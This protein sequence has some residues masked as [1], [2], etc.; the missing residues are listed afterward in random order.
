M[1]FQQVLLRRISFLGRYHLWIFH[2][3][4]GHFPLLVAVGL[5]QFFEWRDS[6]PMGVEALVAATVADTADDTE[7]ATVDTVCSK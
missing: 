4:S 1:Q 7:L 5:K 2:V 6:N 3:G